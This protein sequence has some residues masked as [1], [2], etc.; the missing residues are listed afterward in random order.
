MSTIP[1][2]SS[3]SSNVGNG[4]HFAPA[5][6]AEEDFTDVAA[7][8]GVVGGAL[9][10]DGFC[11]TVSRALVLAAAALTNVRDTNREAGTDAVVTHVLS[12]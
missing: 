10:N 9:F 1:S 4:P 8:D 12:A 11:V 5:A 6:A 7:A 3:S 2:S